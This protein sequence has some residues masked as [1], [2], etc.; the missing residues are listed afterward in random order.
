MSIITFWNDGTEQTGKTLA[1]AA[2]ATQISITH[3]YKTLI[4][5]TEYNDDILD[6]CFWEKN[7]VKKNLGLFGPNTNI[8]L[9]SG[10]NGLIKIMRSNKITPENVK[11][12]TKTVF[13]D[14]LDVLQSF[15]GGEGYYESIKELYPEIIDLANQYYDL[16]IVDLGKR[17][18]ENLRKK[19]LNKSDLIVAAIAQR[20]KSIER[21]HEIRKKDNILSSNKVL[22]MMGRYDKYSKY[23]AK[24]VT[25]FLGEKITVTTIPYNTLLFEAA[26]EAKVPDLFLRL[27]KVDEDDRNAFFI[28]EIERA[29]EN[30]LYTLQSLKMK[31]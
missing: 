23:S 18:D 2:I 15:K 10:I 27:R 14:R 26:E 8:E 9:D 22:I 21:F 19:I 20:L 29:I 17:L 7:K 25:R 3:N 28:R 16:V 4:I 11:D 5:S 24:N 31:A 12:Y 6:N 1:I 30:I 13:K